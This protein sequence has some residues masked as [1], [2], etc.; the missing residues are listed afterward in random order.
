MPLTDARA[1]EL[2]TECRNPMPILEANERVCRRMEFHEDAIAAWLMDF[3][4]SKDLARY[5]VFEKQY[6][7]L[8]DQCSNEVLREGEK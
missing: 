5:G 3:A 4:Q 2:F 1:V 6:L 8:F 7:A